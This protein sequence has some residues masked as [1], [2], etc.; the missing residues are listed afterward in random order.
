MLVHQIVTHNASSTSQEQSQKQDQQNHCRPS[1]IAHC[2]FNCGHYER[3]G[4]N[5]CFCPESLGFHTVYSEC[6]QRQSNANEMPCLQF[7][8][9]CCMCLKALPC[10]SL[11]VQTSSKRSVHVLVRRTQQ[12]CFQGTAFSFSQRTVDVGSEPLISYHSRAGRQ[13]FR[14][15]R[16]ASL[17]NT[18]KLMQ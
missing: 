16:S 5:R 4:Q 9:L 1:W 7:E 10:L 17:W 12:I 14:I 11:S 3:S 18:L 8:A 2:A 15:T 13:I 6:T